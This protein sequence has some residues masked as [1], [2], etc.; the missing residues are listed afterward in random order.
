MHG[1]GE[2]IHYLFEK[3]VMI[4]SY[5]S[6]IANLIFFDVWDSS[7]FVY[8]WSGWILV[9]SGDKNDLEMVP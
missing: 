7:N 3:M 4:W 6:E 2:R 1:N 8:I 9:M 5:A